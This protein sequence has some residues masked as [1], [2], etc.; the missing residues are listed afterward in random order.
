MTVHKQSETREETSAAS[1][2]SALQGN[3][4]KTHEAKKPYK[5]KLTDKQFIQLMVELAAVTNKLAQKQISEKEFVPEL[6]KSCE[7]YGLKLDDLEAEQAT[8][9]L[10]D[11]ENAEFTRLLVERLKDSDRNKRQK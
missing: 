9:K 5:A 7:K 3:E 2:R 8:H 11:A 10:S 4:K 6:E 1:D